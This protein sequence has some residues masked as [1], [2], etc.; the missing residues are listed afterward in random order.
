MPEHEQTEKQHRVE[1]LGKI[2]TDALLQK[3]SI[4]ATIRDEALAAI[5]RQLWM[6]RDADQWLDL[7]ASELEARRA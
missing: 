2:S 1:L 5:D 4:F 3:R 7:I 6:A